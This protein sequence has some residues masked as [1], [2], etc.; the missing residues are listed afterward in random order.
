MVRTSNAQLQARVRE[1]EEEIN[2]IRTQQN[3]DA[4]ATQLLGEMN[5]DEYQTAMENSTNGSAHHEPI[6]TIQ[7]KAKVPSNLPKFNGKKGTDARQWLFDIENVC[8]INGHII[9][10]NN[11]TLPG[12]AGT[13]MQTPANGFFQH[14]ATSTPAEKQTWEDFKECL[15]NQFE[16]TNY[17]ANLRRQIHRLRQTGDIED[18]N[19]EY[20]NLIFR[21]KDMS[22]VDQVMHYTQGLKPRVRSYVRLENPVRLAQ[23]MDAAK[24]YEHAHFDEAEKGDS[25]KKSNQNKPYHRPSNNSTKGNFKSRFD[26]NQGKANEKDVSKDP[27]KPSVFCKYCKKK[28]HTIEECRSLKYKEQQK[29]KQSSS[30]QGNEQ[31]V[32][33]RG[34]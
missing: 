3:A 28:G 19:G 18:Y 22:E 31:P 26:R 25:G 12:I 23:A 4:Q 6:S 27:S 33:S 2:N 1:L 10:N 29:K 16:G 11:L 24:R 14:W 8:K 32:K 21:V 9:S 15:I 34:A 7:S 5:D 30:D 17:Q 20:A 13:A